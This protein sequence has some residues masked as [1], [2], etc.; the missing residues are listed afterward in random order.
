MNT[1]DLKYIKWH[2]LLLMALHDVLNCN[3]KRGYFKTS[4]SY[5]NISVI[6]NLIIF[7][8]YIFVLFYYCY[9]INDRLI[10]FGC[11]NQSLEEQFYF[12]IRSQFPFPQYLVYT[13]TQTKV[14]AGWTAVIDQ[15]SYN[16]QLF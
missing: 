15:L 3:S 6:C 11:W 14:G 1:V 5:F 7:F 9:F 2:K 16:T 13:Q 8:T 12:E 10:F 4:L